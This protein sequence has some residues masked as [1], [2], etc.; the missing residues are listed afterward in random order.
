MRGMEEPVRNQNGAAEIVNKPAHLKT[1]DELYA[2]TSQKCICKFCETLN[3]T[4]KSVC[5]AC[6][7]KLI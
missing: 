3:D 2:E 5:V 7:R 6:G 4:G 1:L